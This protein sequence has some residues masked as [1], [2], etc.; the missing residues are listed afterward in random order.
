MKKAF[1]VIEL[2][3]VMAIS[4]IL[5]SLGSS[6][7]KVLMSPIDNIKLNG[8]VCEVSNMISYGKYYWRNK[9]E[10][11]RLVINDSKNTIA[12]TDY[13]YNPVKVLELPKEVWFI[14]DYDIKIT[15]AGH[16]ALSLS[17]YVVEDNEKYR[18]AISTG[19]DTVNIY[20]E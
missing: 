17:I 19:V 6:L 4:L 2:I 3:T 12:I 16:L 13:T 11:G 10:V 18:I 14:S 5:V 20:K 1:T 8:A 7:M 9:N 15:S